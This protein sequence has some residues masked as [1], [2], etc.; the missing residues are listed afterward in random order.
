MD[1]VQLGCMI[2]FMFRKMCYAESVPSHGR[3]STTTC[4]FGQICALL[5][6]C[7]QTARVSEPV[8]IRLGTWS[9]GLIVLAQIALSVSVPQNDMGHK[10]VLLGLGLA[11][12]LALR[13]RKGS[14]FC[15][16]IAFFYE[17]TSAFARL[18]AWFC[19]RG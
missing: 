16:S 19:K 18:G 13:T 11:A 14:Y 17:T 7:R 15:V 2:C 3:S 5:C 9:Q 10:S 8:S 4:G 6:A 1:N 12:V